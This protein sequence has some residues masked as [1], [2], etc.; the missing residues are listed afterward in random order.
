MKNQ[1][2]PN[3]LQKFKDS[4]FFNIHTIL[5]GKI[6]TYDDTQ[7]KAKIQVLVKLK[8]T[9]NNVYNI[10]PI[11]GVPVIFPISAGFELKYPLKK[12]DGCLLLFSE[13]PIGNYLV[14]SGMIVVDADDAGRFELTD[15]I[16]IPGLF[17]FSSIPAPTAKIEIETSGNIIIESTA[18][19]IKI[20]P[21]G[22]ITLDDG[23]EAY[24]L[25][26]VLDTWITSVLISIFNAHT[27]SSPAGGSTGTPSSPLTPPINYLSTFI[28][29][30]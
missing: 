26:N 20:E 17:Q 15:C 5:P 10:D 28:K 1:N 19:K 27:H 22:A 3:I 12:D 25:G 29:G 6:V 4:M 11:D 7:K 21:S 8:D 13:A 24:V 9:E 14:G 2:M 30:K 16:A 18:G 23:T